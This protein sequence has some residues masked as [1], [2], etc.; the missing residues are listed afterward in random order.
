MAELDR[1]RFGDLDSLFPLDFRI[2]EDNIGAVEP[3]RRRRVNHPTV[4]LADS[5]N[6]R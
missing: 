5:R 1:V 3:G 6:Q 4:A 2:L